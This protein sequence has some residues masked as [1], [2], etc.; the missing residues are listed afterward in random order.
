MPSAAIRDGW[1]RL[2]GL[3]CQ[4][5]RA[6]LHRAGARAGWWLL[7]ALVL[8]PILLLAGCGQPGG[9]SQYG[10]APYGGIAAEPVLGAW[11]IITRRRVHRMTPGVPISARRRRA[12]TFPSN[13][14]AR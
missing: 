4:R 13:G 12:T 5:H 2:A 10:A 1:H 9:Y 11:S 6:G 14:S 8:A 7:A 3:N